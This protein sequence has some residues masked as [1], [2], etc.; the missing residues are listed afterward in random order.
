[1]SKYKVGD[2]LYLNG[3]TN[4]YCV[5][6]KVTKA[7]YEIEWDSSFSFPRDGIN[8]YPKH[9]IEQATY[10]PKYIDTPIW[11]MLEGEDT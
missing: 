7:S 11:R 6:I 1:M 8:S 4:P 9:I 2:S 5:V 3:Q 10:I